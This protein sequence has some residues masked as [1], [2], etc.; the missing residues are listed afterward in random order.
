VE[1]AD[2]R[3]HD[4]S[5]LLSPQDRAQRGSHLGRR[6]RT[7]SDLVDERLEQ[8]EVLPID[9]RNVDRSTTKLAHRLQASEAAADDYNAVGNCLARGRGHGLFNHRSSQNTTASS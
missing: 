8:V 9:E 7:G 4:A 2:L 1:A 6:E 5:I 3:E